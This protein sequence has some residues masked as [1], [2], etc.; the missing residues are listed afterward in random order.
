MN[1]DEPRPDAAATTEEERVRRVLGQVGAERPQTPPEVTAKLADT[2]ADLVQERS[3]AD[4][5][6]GRAPTGGNPR[7]GRVLLAAAAAVVVLGTGGVALVTLTGR[8]AD[9]SS[10]KA[11]GTAADSVGP[12]TPEE[13]L[14]LEGKPRRGT[15]APAGGLP[16]LRPDHLA[17]D[18]RGLLRRQ[19]DRAQ[20]DAAR[21]RGPVPMVDC[22]TPPGASAQAQT[23]MYGDTAASLVVRPRGRHLLVE[24]WSCAA[25]TR[26]A[27]VR[28]PAP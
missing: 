20:G 3:D 4:A 10:S 19:A 17:V 28:L 18:V 1:P 21:R 9:T 5:A 16:V 25:Q 23:V 8:S 14:P 13:S 15:P 24:I 27:R 7:R 2:L 26:L 22:V 12:G 11:G 6:K